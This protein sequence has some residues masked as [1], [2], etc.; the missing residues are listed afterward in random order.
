MSAILMYHYLRHADPD[1]AHGAL[2]V[3]PAEFRSQL[4][5]LTRMGRRSILGPEYS[6]LLAD[7]RLDRTVWITFDDGFA[8]NYHEGLPALVAAGHRATF[9]V[10]VEPCLAGHPGYMSLAQ[11]RE[12][13]AAGMEIGSHT[14]T[15]ARLTTLG[16]AD[17][18]REVGDSRRRLED[19]L[20]VAVTSFCYP[21][22]NWN[23]TVI[24][25]V[26]AAGYTLATSTIRGNR[27]SEADRWLLRRVMVQPGRTGWRFRHGFTPLYH[28]LHA[29]KN[30]N[31]WKKGR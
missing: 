27:N 17:L 11:L 22:G 10:T 9:F 12:M 26:R 5:Q 4:D 29:W 6:R 15:H 23:R 2:S 20:G 21:Y 8:D 1:D 18:A 25:A 7:G 19:A 24:E 31:K 14:M 16:P 3:P 30:R 28:W 13:V